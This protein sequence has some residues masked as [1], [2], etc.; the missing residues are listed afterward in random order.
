MDDLFFGEY[1]LFFEDEDSTT[2]RTVNNDVMAHN[3]RDDFMDNRF[4][5]IILRKER[6]DT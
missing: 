5:S 2:Y 1:G 3:V 6:R 4:E